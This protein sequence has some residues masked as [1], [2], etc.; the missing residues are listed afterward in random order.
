MDEKE[1]TYVLSEFQLMLFNEVKQFFAMKC[2]DVVSENAANLNDSNQLLSA[3]QDE[4]SDCSETVFNTVKKRSKKA[5][6][7]PA[8]AEVVNTTVVLENAANLNDNNQLLSAEQDEGNDVSET[9][10]LSK[11]VFMYTAHNKVCITPT[12]YT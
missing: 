10:A 7:Q 3:D 6:P 2:N 5:V 9:A 12:H 11:T 4:D 8:T 1:V